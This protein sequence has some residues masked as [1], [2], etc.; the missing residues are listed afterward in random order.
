MPQAKFKVE[1]ER[2][3]CC[4]FCKKRRKRKKTAPVKIITPT[5]IE[6]AK[7]DV[8]EEDDFTDWWNKYFASVEV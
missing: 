3:G 1:N 7:R 5:I 2:V 8:M 6:E 4:A